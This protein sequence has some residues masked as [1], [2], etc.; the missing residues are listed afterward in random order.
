MTVKA[1]IRPRQWLIDYVR[2]KM[3]TPAALALFTLLAA[4]GVFAEESK[5]RAVP[6]PRVRLGPVSGVA[7]VLPPPEVTVADAKAPVVMDKFIVNEKSAI[8]REPSHP[9]EQKG[10]FSA[11]GGGYLLKG[12][13]TKAEWEAGLGRGCRGQT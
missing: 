1:L 11:L 3:R 12:G 8:P 13:G 6:Q 7:V 4:G 10:A 5:A 2:K 9:E